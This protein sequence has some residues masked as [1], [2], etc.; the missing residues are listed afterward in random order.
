MQAIAKMRQCLMLFRRAVS[1]VPGVFERLLTGRLVDEV[2]HGCAFP[3]ISNNASDALR[4]PLPQTGPGRGFGHCFNWCKARLVARRPGFWAGKFGIELLSVG[5]AFCWVFW[6]SGS[7]HCR[8]SCWREVGD[9]RFG[10]GDKACYAV[11]A[12][13]V[14]KAV[15]DGQWFCQIPLVD[16]GLVS[17]ANAVGVF[18]SGL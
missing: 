7:S 13:G 18:G 5:A 9:H 1:R 4:R 2:A 17:G 8:F 12:G 10:G 16:A 3:V 11:S 15:G 6:R 14:G